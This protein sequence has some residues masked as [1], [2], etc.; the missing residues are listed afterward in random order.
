MTKE[1]F[2]KFISE[3]TRTGKLATVNEDGSPHVVPV[4]FVLD[5]DNLIFSTGLNSVKYK[6]MSR[7]PRVCI[8]VDE[9]KDLYSFAKID[10]SVTFS[11]DPDERLNWA[12]SIA[13]RYMG[14]ENAELYGKR[15][16]GPD[17]VVVIVKPQRIY[18]YADVAGW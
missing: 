14:E 2:K 7:D 3:G 12:T 1:E 8:S 11:N 17:E 9:E 10:G 16:S 4:W 5:G 6:N 18:A 13:S 15:N